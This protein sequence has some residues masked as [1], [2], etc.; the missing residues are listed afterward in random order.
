[1]SPAQQR[2]NKRIL[3]VDDE[4]TI[5]ATLPV[6]LR[7]H[8]FDVTVASTVPEA[9]EH[10]QTQAFDLL[11][12]DLNISRD[13]DGYDVVRAVHKRQPR[14]AVV[15]LTAYPA[16]ESAVRGIREGVDDYL[17]KPSDTNELIASLDARLGHRQGEARILS[18]SH[19]RLL[20]RMRQLLL[21]REGYEVVSAQGLSASLE[22][23]KEGGFD[24]LVL[25]HSLEHTEKQQIVDAFCSTSDAPVISLRR[26]T[27][28]QPVRGAE[29][30]IEP[31]PEPMLK[32]IA[33]ILSRRAPAPLT[34]ETTA[35]Q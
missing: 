1:M 31:D 13:G 34:G 20:L 28:E 33:E 2:T 18:V 35:Q 23:C 25:G 12:C 10:V 16:L 7:K 29:H 32:L 6:V 14:C 5:R 8:G 24:L 15:I 9:I 21:E 27:G 19:D 3:F 17:I 26:N 4:W 22:A 11:L 30:Y